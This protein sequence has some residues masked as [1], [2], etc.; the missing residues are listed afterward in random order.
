MK[1]SQSRVAKIEAG[2]PPVPL[3]L[4]VWTVLSAGA[5]KTTTSL[6]LR[7]KRSLSKRLAFSIDRVALVISLLLAL[8]NLLWRCLQ[9]SAVTNPEYSDNIFTR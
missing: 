5:T 6:V 7:F 2:D 9:A 4:L 1:S 3:D 8:L